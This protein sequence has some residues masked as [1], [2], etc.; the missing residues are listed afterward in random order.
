[1]KIG[2]PFRVGSE[3]M[4]TVPNGTVIG[5]PVGYGKILAGPDDDGYFAME[6][7]S[8]ELNK[9]IAYSIWPIER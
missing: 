2:T 8:G 7:N 9:E 1:M 5:R 6:P 4:I 3:V